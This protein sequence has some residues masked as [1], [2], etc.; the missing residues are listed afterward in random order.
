[1][2]KKAKSLNPNQQKRIEELI[3]TFQ[4]GKTFIVNG[5]LALVGAC[6]LPKAFY[7]SSR[8]NGFIYEVGLIGRFEDIQK[9]T[10]RFIRKSKRSK[11]NILVLDNS[12]I[13]EIT[14]ETK[15]KD[16]L[17]KITELAET[18]KAFLNG[19][20]FHQETIKNT[21]DEKYQK[22]TIT[23]RP[24]WDELIDQNKNAPFTDFV[25]F[26]FSKDSSS[27]IKK[28]HLY[29]R[30][31]EG[32]KEKDGIITTSAI[33]YAD[34]IADLSIDTRKIS[35]GDLSLPHLRFE[36]LRFWADIILARTWKYGDELLKAEGFTNEEIQQI[37]TQP[38][39]PTKY[40]YWENLSHPYVRDLRVVAFFRGE[41]EIKPRTI[42]H[43]NERSTIEQEHQKE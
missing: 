32:L 10:Q 36:G 20:A 12:L 8:Y 27:R 26:E 11:K 13:Y 40:T 4:N 17:Q 6:E 33:E 2:Q 29:G 31:L 14:P 3:N 23:N 18:K 24:L 7:T 43:Q 9:R 21:A 1:M 25:P 41:T 34:D 15:L 35:R 19:E 16:A 30:I 42:C 22:L 5:S 38:T 28:L 39:L 37:K